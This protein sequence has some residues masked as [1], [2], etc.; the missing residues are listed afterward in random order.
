[1]LKF[2]PITKAMRVYVII[3]DQYKK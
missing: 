2:V 1:M 3:G